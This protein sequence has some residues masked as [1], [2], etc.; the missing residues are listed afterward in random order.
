MDTFWTVVTVVAV[1]AILALAFWA[2][3][4]APFRVPRRPVHR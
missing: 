1:V 4:V 3:V 2:V